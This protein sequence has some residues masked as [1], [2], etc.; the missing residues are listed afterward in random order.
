MRNIEKGVLLAEFLDADTSKYVPSFIAWIKNTPEYRYFI[1]KK[2]SLKIKRTWKAKRFNSYFETIDIDSIESIKDGMIEYGKLCYL[3]KITSEPS[4]TNPLIVEDLD[5]VDMRIGDLKVKFDGKI[6]TLR[7]LS[8][9][10]GFDFERKEE[11][12]RERLENW[13][14]EVE[15]TILSSIDDYKNHPL[16]LPKVKIFNATTIIQL[17]YLVLANVFLISVYFVKIPFFENV[18]ASTTNIEFFIYLLCVG[19]TFVY[20]LLFIGT[21]IYRKKKYGYYSKARD[22]VLEGIY[23]EKERCEKKLKYYLYEQLATKGDMKAK[24]FEFSKISKYYPYIGYIRK[25]LS[26]KRRVRVDKITVGEVTGL[27]V[28]LICM[29]TLIVFMFI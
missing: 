3:V 11:V 27:I 18:V 10:E 21:L 26:L 1:E 29:I 28:T 2:N 5:M 24:I 16:Y 4:Y 12:V 17:I 15:E 9:L 20:D 7:E 19:F 23:Q 6:I 14:R 13:I 22:G 25:H 8:K